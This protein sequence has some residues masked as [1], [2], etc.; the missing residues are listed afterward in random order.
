LTPEAARR[1]TAWRAVAISGLEDG[2]YSTEPGTIVAC[3]RALCPAC[4]L[5][6]EVVRVL[7]DSDGET[8]K[9]V[10]QVAPLEECTQSWLTDRDVLEAHA[11]FG[12]EALVQDE[13]DY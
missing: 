12:L 13:D 7:D 1:L 2:C 5:H 9:D 6:H 8:R 10:Y 11:R 3:M 4:G